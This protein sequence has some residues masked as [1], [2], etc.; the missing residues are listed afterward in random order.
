MDRN[1]LTFSAG[2]G[3][4]KKALTRPTFCRSNRE[5]PLPVDT[6]YL[7]TSRYQF[8]PPLR[9][10]R[11]PKKLI[12]E[13]IITAGGGLWHP[14]TQPL[15]LLRLNVDR[16]PQQLKN[17]LAGRELAEE[18]FGTQASGD[19]L[20]AVKAFAERNKEDALKTA[21]KVSP[22]LAPLPIFIPLGP[23]SLLPFSAQ[24]YRIAWSPPGRFGVLLFQICNRSTVHSIRCFISYSDDWITLNVLGP[25]GMALV[26]VLFRNFQFLCLG[27]GP[28]SSLQVS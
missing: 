16:N 6:F 24:T 26:K 9:Q 3:R 11:G 23:F 17:I 21:P 2:H 14:N 5:T 4:A 20:K 15:N 27:V 10:R 25:G 8:S 1:I 13:R 12:G 19:E 18:F 28:C 22:F 7:S